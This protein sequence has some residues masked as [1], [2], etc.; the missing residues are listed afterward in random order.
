MSSGPT[1]FPF[2]TL[3][4]AI[5]LIEGLGAVVETVAVQVAETGKRR[6]CCGQFRC[7]HWFVKRPENG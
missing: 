4:F 1:S 5:R 2:L 3:Y 7:W 6:Q